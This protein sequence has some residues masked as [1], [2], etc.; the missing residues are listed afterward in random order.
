MLWSQFSAAEGHRQGGNVVLLGMRTCDSFCIYTNYNPGRISQLICSLWYF[1]SGDDVH[2]LS[3]LVSPGEREREE[4]ETEGEREREGMRER[5]RGRR[6]KRET[7]R[8]GELPILLVRPSLSR[9][10]PVHLV[11][12]GAR[13]APCVCL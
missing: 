2:S 7:E 4:R 5:E 13:G 8:E 12:S 11:I 10:E 6:R 3:L 9:L 1:K